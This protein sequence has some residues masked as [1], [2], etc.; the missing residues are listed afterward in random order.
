MF[1]GLIEEV[2]SVKST[3]L[4][5]GGL[6]LTILAPHVCQG[7]QIG[8]S[9]N[10]N[11]A[12]QTV[13]DLKE[14]TFSVETVEET[15]KKT[16]LGSFKQGTK[17]NLERALLPTSRL[18]GHFVLGHVDTVGK[19]VSVENLTGS[20]LIRISFDGSFSKYIIPVGSIAVDGIS[21][22]VAE[23]ESNTFTIAV[24]PHTYKNTTLSVKRIS[25]EVNLEFDVLGKY[26]IK[27]LNP[28][29][30]SKLSEAWLNEMGY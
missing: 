10:I 25:N 11:G 20:T 6:R 9:I 3:S 4:L 28:Q 27:S 29:Q 21:L 13:V 22:T 23:I 14:N 15:L 17:V 7:T 26:V 2:G 24:I 1:T 19:I 16:N 30:N 5:G 18:G 8:D 12:C